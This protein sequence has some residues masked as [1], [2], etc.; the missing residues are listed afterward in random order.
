MA[1]CVKSSMYAH[2]SKTR[3]P[4]LTRPKDASRL[5]FNTKYRHACIDVHCKA[6]ADSETNVVGSEPAYV[7]LKLRKP[8]GVVFTQK[9]TGGPVYVDEVTPGG[10]ADKSGAVKVGDVLTK[11]S[12][13][14]LKAGKDGQ[15]ETEGY[16]Q[17]PYDNWET[18]MFDCEGQ[19][20]K[21]V[22]SAL[23]SNNERWGIKDVTLVFRKPA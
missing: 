23:K 21:T 9:P 13:V 3:P 15:Y 22:M 2:V 20:F 16:G 5:T 10:N 19:D 4:V 17:R 11:C 6:S 1:A 8:V 12:A 18:V 7:T 14:V